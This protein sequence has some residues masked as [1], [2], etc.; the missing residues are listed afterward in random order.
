MPVDF[1]A[2]DPQ[3]RLTGATKPKT[4]NPLSTEAKIPSEATKF[5]MQLLGTGGGRVLS[6]ATKNQIQPTAPEP[7]PSKLQPAYPAEG[8]QLILDHRPPRQEST[9]TVPYTRE[10]AI[11]SL[12]DTPESIFR[13]VS[14]IPKG[15]SRYLSGNMGSNIANSVA[16]TATAPFK[17]IANSFSEV[18]S[19]AINAGT[20]ALKGKT[21]PGSSV[22]P[23]Q[24]TSSCL[25]FLQTMQKVH[26]T[27]VSE[28]LLNIVS[29]I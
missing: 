6:D 24:K 5:Q 29:S 3:A 1:V 23:I 4:P 7:K 27:K 14:S 22:T 13:G 9:E 8:M 26:T 20:Q 25:R 15:M 12:A 19:K 17:N 16:E 21:P 11:K 2:E 28:R 18:G 10:R